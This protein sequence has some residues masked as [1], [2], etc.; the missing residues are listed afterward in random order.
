VSSYFTLQRDASVISYCFDVL[1]G[2]CLQFTVKWSY[3]ANSV[4]QQ[5][6]TQ[7]LYM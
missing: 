4:R 2:H 3:L 5:A 7:W 6:T 1:E